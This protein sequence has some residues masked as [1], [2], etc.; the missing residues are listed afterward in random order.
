MLLLVMNNHT[1]LRIQEIRKENKA[2]LVDF[3]QRNK[4]EFV[5]IEFDG[6]GD[7][8]QMEAVQIHP[9][10]KDHVVDQYIP[11]I[12]FYQRY[13]GGQWNI[14]EELKQVAFQDAVDD[15]AYT[16]LENNH[17]GWEINDGSYGEIIINSDGSGKIEYNQRVMET[18]F[19]ESS[20]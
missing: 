10:D 19:E 16:L 9:S 7:S 1:L 8:G 13:D 17:G 12:R 11:F 6:S 5:S 15:F 3:M 18:E 2:V 4:I 14:I 20:F